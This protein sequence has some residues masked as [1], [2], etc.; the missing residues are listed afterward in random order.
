MLEWLEVRTLSLGRRTLDLSTSTSTSTLSSK[1]YGDIRI[2]CGSEGLTKEKLD[3]YI[4]L[5]TADRINLGLSFY[6]SARKLDLKDDGDCR[7]IV[8]RCYYCCYHL[9]RAL[10]FLVLRD[11]MDDHS[12][13]PKALEKVLTEEDNTFADRLDEW[14]GIRNEI[15]YSPFPK[16]DKP[17]SETAAEML[18]GTGEFMESFAP[19]FRERGVEFDARI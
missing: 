6:G 5:V 3:E 10:I 16:V 14:R 4:R 13:L 12:R 1:E 18:E 19:Y 2:I 11:D 8:S 9:A 7:S 17:L 15:E